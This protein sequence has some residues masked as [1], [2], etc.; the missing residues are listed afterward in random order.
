[1]AKPLVDLSVPA[2][3]GAVTGVIDRGCEFEGKL[4]FQGTVRI[5]GMFRGE[6]YTPDVL[7]V[8]EG[9]RVYG[10]IDAGVVIISGEV[11]GSVRAKHRVEIHQPAIFR[12]DI[13]TPSLSVDEGVIF[14]GSSKMVHAP[15]PPPN[16]PFLAK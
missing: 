5:G 4:C 8:G 9:A 14:E 2:T 7:V 11:N 3:Q 1:M 6:I 16:E 15:V 13:L 12:G 10:T